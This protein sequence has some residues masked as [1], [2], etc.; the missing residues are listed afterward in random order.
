MN[1]TH[2]DML[3]LPSVA[4]Q[5]NADVDK[6]KKTKSKNKEGK[7]IGCQL[8]GMAQWQRQRKQK[9]ARRDKSG[10]NFNRH[11]S[12]QC[13]RRLL[14]TDYYYYVLLLWFQYISHRSARPCTHRRS[15][16]CDICRRDRQCR[17]RRS[18]SRCQCALHDNIDWHRHRHCHRHEAGQRL[19]PTRSDC[20]AR[21]A[22]KWKQKATFRFQFSLLLSLKS[23]PKNSMV[24]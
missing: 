12:V 18:V 16:L 6:K 11:L 24:E 7:K 10:K 2:D 14:S 22:I 3:T 1:C 19:I 9:I 5:I 15:H 23:Q 13:V 20:V 4:E 8:K 21:A 17:Y